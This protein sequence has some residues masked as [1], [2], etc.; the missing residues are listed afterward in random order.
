MEGHPCQNSMSKNGTLQT[1]ST[2]S[3]TSDPNGSYWYGSGGDCECGDDCS[4]FGSKS[5]STSIELEPEPEENAEASSKPASRTIN[6]NVA[7]LDNEPVAA[8]SPKQIVSARVLLGS[9]SSNSFKFHVRDYPEIDWKEDR[10]VPCPEFSCFGHTWRLSI[11]H[12]NSDLHSEGGSISI[13]LV[14]NFFDEAMLVPFEIQILNKGGAAV[15]EMVATHFFDPTNL[16]HG[17][18]WNDIISHSTLIDPTK[19]ILGPKGTLTVAVSFMGRGDEFI[20]KNPF[21]K[22]LNGL[23]LEDDYSDISFEVAAYEFNVENGTKR[24]KTQ[25]RFPCHY[26]VLK[27]CAPKLACLFN[28]PLNGCSSVA[29]INDVCP[30]IFR[31]LLWYV[32]GGTIPESVLKNRA[33]TLD[34]IKVA[35]KYSITGAKL[36]AEAALVKLVFPKEG[37]FLMDTDNNTGSDCGRNII[38]YLMYAESN[39]L[40]LLKEAAVNF[41]V[42]SDAET[43]QRL[44]FGTGNIPSNLVKDLLVTKMNRGFSQQHRCGYVRCGNDAFKS[45][46]VTELRRS[47]QKNGIKINPDSSREEMEK[48]LCERQG[49]SSISAPSRKIG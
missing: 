12:S 9:S 21:A 34:L 33:N 8:M 14:H 22:T 13:R 2:S 36:V 46:N 10:S 31:H 38:D 5:I 35:N 41:I 47:I 18:E 37:V 39:R 3:S 29:M 40:P 42:V 7:A 43:I 27:K 19:N 45:M 17:F 44:S 11:C 23:F 48:A 20:P 28:W 26:V 15:R 16:R 32:Y 4:S 24:L 6:H 30:T 49:K 1:Q 25:A